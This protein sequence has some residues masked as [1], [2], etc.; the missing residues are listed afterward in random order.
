MLTCKS[1]T[2]F[3]EDKLL[4]HVTHQ[5][6]HM[7]QALLSNSTRNS[8]QDPRS[9]VCMYTHICTCVWHLLDHYEEQQQQQQNQKIKQQKMFP[10]TKIRM[11]CY[12]HR[13]DHYFICFCLFAASTNVF[14]ILS[15]PGKEGERDVSKA[16]YLTVWSHQWT[17]SLVPW[18][19]HSDGPVGHLF[20]LFAPVMVSSMLLHA[21]VCFSFLGPLG[22]R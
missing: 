12:T 10:R 18:C 21:S 11:V 6:S 1:P 14:S 2:V 13:L 22:F 15:L 20:L 5:S 7:I 16:Q 17:S 8:M 4:F 9:T 3:L 19:P